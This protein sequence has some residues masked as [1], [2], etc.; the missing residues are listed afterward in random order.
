[1]PP[2]IS[3]YGFADDHTAIT[4]FKPTPAAETLAISELQ[5]CA[6]IINDWMNANKLKMNTS[7]TEFIMFGS[8]PQLNKCSTKVITICGDQIKL[9]PCIRYL[10]AFLDD[11]LNFKEHV[12]RKCQTAMF[13]YFKIKSIRKFL[14][15]EVTEVLCLSLVFLP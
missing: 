3:V 13:N 1:M 4:P 14:T 7:K 15:K 8:R 9:Q 2:N 6:I 11:T 12:K 10:G 5:D